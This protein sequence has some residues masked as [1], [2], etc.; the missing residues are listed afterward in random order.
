MHFYLLRLL[1]HL[2]LF[3]LLLLLLLSDSVLHG[4]GVEILDGRGLLTRHDHHLQV[5]LLCDHLTLQL[6]TT[7]N[8]DLEEQAVLSK[9]P[10]FHRK[11]LV[12]LPGLRLPV[13]EFSQATVQP[14]HTVLQLCTHLF[15]LKQGLHHLGTLQGSGW[16]RLDRLTVRKG[17]AMVSRGSL[18]MR[19]AS[20]ISACRS[21]DP[22][23]TSA[24]GSATPPWKQEPEQLFNV[25]HACRELRPSLYESQADSTR[26]MVLL[27]AV[28]PSRTSLLSSSSC[29]ACWLTCWK[30]A[31]EERNVQSVQKMNARHRECRGGERTHRGPTCSTCGET[32]PAEKED[33]SPLG[34]TSTLAPL[35]P[36]LLTCHSC[37]STL[38]ASGETKGLFQTR[39]LVLIWP[40]RSRTEWRCSQN[41]SLIPWYL[42]VTLTL[43][44]LV[45]TSTMR[46][47]NCKPTL[48]ISSNEQTIIGTPTQLFCFAN[49]PHED[50]YRVLSSSILSAG[51]IRFPHSSRFWKDWKVFS[52]CGI[53]SRQTYGHTEHIGCIAWIHFEELLFLPGGG[54]GAAVILRVAVLLA[55][56]LLRLQQP[57]SHRVQRGRETRTFSASESHASLRARCSS[58]GFAARLIA[59]NSG[60]MGRRCSLKDTRKV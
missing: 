58:L 11:Q 14:R 12:E 18:R 7:G 40:N 37:S 39:S 34:F 50:P 10:Q 6:Q 30:S 46:K 59:V 8:Q 4:G 29:F 44:N 60:M 19:A 9:H 27:A 47:T 20:L 15:R 2:W 52:C 1:H 56:S 31:A 3:L 53:S 21:W 5:L 28:T 22:V 17:A 23:W 49:R 41:S 45:K 36:N 13:K 25:D 26:P 55:Q 57:A 48:W 33:P 38:T 42:A 51:T 35:S 43:V 32:L 24:L 16:L 54:G